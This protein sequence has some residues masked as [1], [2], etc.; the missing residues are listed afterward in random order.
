MAG[1]AQ[2]DEKIIDVI[3]RQ[4]DKYCSIEFFPPKTEAG[5]ELLFKA[6]D[7]LKVCDPQFVDVTWGAGGSTSELTV[8][9]CKRVKAN[10]K[11]PSK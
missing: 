5:I 3:N 9:L 6:L 7:N 4:T 11:I 1:F 8:E 2:D 10:G